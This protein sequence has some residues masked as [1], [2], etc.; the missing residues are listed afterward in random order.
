MHIL[1]IL[2]KRKNETAL[3]LVRYQFTFTFIAVK[4]VIETHSTVN[5]KNE[6]KFKASEENGCAKFYV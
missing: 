6:A 1:H 5:S 3:L 2:Q 4:A